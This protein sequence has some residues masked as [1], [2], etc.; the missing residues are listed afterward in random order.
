MKTKVAVAFIHGVGKR[1]QHDLLDGGNNM[2]RMA[3]ALRDEFAR[4]MPF[5]EAETALAFM[6]CHW[7]IDSGLQSL[8]NALFAKMKPLIR[9]GMLRDIFATMLGDAVAYQ[10]RTKTPTLY[11]AIHKAIALRLSRLAALAGPTAP[12][13]IIAHSLGSVIASNYIYDWQKD[14]VP[15]QVREMTTNT[16]LEQMS[17]LTYLFTLGSPLALWSLRFD[18]F[19][20]PITVPA[21]LLHTYYGP[22]GGG[23]VNIYDKDDTI[24]FPLQSLNAAYERAVIDQQVN[25]GG[26]LEFW[27]PSSHLGYWLDRDV[28]EIIGRA[29]AETWLAANGA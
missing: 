16:P 8:E 17:T 15:P 12:L 3:L 13:I 2:R 5:V 14:I 9:I 29:L 21:P 28:V 26:I 6:P 23:W 22:M 10:Q 24:A 20:E 25:V 11:D 18:T 19:G 7:D 1:S 27:N 4:H